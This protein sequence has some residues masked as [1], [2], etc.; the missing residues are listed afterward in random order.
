M[1]LIWQRLDG[2]R[3]GDSMERHPLRGEGERDGQRRL[4]EGGS[5]WDVNK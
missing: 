3:L 2:P 1:H 5:F 4:W